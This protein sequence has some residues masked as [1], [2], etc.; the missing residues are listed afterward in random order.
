MNLDKQLTQV[1]LFCVAAELRRRQLAGI[2]I[3][4][5]LRRLHYQLS[6]S[7]RGPESE[8]TQEESGVAE[9]IN[10]SAAAETLGC[11]ER[12]IR[13]IAADLDGTRIAGRWCFHRTT[14]TEY[15]TARRDSIT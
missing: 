9:L 14:V 13:R 7:V 8:A 2:P 3:R 4:D 5:E 15:S 10:T 11:T 6:T 1:A 12:H